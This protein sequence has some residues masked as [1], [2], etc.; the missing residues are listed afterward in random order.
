MK[1]DSWAVT[2]DPDGRIGPYAT[3]GNQWVSYDDISEIKRKVS[4]T[5][6]KKLIGKFTINLISVHL[7][8]RVGSRRWN[9]MGT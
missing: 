5:I 8:Q 6:F 4:K 1:K 2:R 3:H 9:G 7:D